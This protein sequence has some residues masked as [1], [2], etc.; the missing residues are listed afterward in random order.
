MAQSY[1]TVL[2]QGSF[3][4][5]TKCKDKAESQVFHVPL[6]MPTG[7]SH[8]EFNIQANNH[9]RYSYKYQQDTGAVVIHAEVKSH[10]ECAFVL[11]FQNEPRS[12][13][14]LT[15]KVIGQANFCRPPE[16]LTDPNPTVGQYRMSVLNE[17]S[18]VKCQLKLAE[19]LAKQQHQKFLNFVLDRS[20]EHLKYAEDVALFES[21]K[22]LKDTNEAI[23]FQAEIS[24]SLEVAK[25]LTKRLDVVR[26][27]VE[28]L[29][30]IPLENGG[31]SF[32]YEE[33]IR[34]Y[35]AAWRKYRT[36]NEWCRRSSRFCA[37]EGPKLK[38]LISPFGFF[39]SYKEEFDRANFRISSYLAEIANIESAIKNEVTVLLALEMDATMSERF[40]SQRS[41]R[42]NSV[43][44]ILDKL[45]LKTQ[46]T[47][48]ELQNNSNTFLQSLMDTVNVIN[49][50]SCA[51]YPDHEGCGSS[52]KKMPPNFDGGSAAIFP[53]IDGI[54]TLPDSPRSPFPVNPGMGKNWSAAE[55]SDKVCL[56]L[57]FFAGPNTPQTPKPKSE[58]IPFAQING[59]DVRFYL[60]SSTLIYSGNELI[61][62]K[63][64]GCFSR[65]LLRTNVNVVGLRFVYGDGSFMDGETR[66]SLFVNSG[67]GLQ[68]YICSYESKSTHNT[69]GC[70]GKMSLSLS[71]IDPSS[72]ARLSQLQQE[73]RKLKLDYK[74]R[75]DEVNRIQ[76]Y[77]N[78]IQG[79]LD[80]EAIDTDRLKNISDELDQAAATIETLKRDF[81]RIRRSTL[82]EQFYA[83]ENLKN[84][85][86]KNREE[87]ELI[88]RRLAESQRID[89]S[90]LGKINESRQQFLKGVSGDVD[91]RG[92]L[93]QFQERLLK[94]LEASF[95]QGNF[96]SWRELVADW[97]SYKQILLYDL[98]EHRKGEDSIAHVNQVIQNI[99]QYISAKV[100][101]YGFRRDL[102]LPADIKASIGKRT[103]QDPFARAV[104]DRLN[105]INKGYVEPSGEVAIR[106]FIHAMLRSID[107]FFW[108]EESKFKAL[109]KRES[110]ERGFIDYLD[111]VARVGVG[112]T[113]VIGDFVDFCEL[114][115]GRDLCTLNGSTLTLQERAL[116]GLGLFIG[117]GVLYREI[118]AGKTIKDADKIE[119]RMSAYHESVEKLKTR[120]SNRLSE[121]K[122]REATR[123]IITETFE[124]GKNLSIEEVA[125]RG[126]KL[127][128]QR[129]DYLSEIEVLDGKALNEAL[130]QSFEPAWK[131]NGLI[132]KGKTTK[133]IT[134]YRLYTP[135]LKVDSKK[136]IAEALQGK[137]YLDPTIVKGKT[138]EEVQKV[139]AIPNRHT[140]YMKL[141]I[142]VGHEIVYGEASPNKFSDQVVA[143]QFFIQGLDKLGDDYMTTIKR[144]MLDGVIK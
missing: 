27:G 87:A 57:E 44:E 131:A 41:E 91:A 118:R 12:W 90:F 138:V 58:G 70:S 71:Q 86:I 76:A 81:E 32:A 29:F 55:L 101:E 97:K 5:E 43:G 62:S 63:S 132:V 115:T 36:K 77:L 85:E 89:L 26:S 137:W 93:N 38:D 125:A 50:L 19:S 68:K 53:S 16:P 111:G 121:S 1:Q 3:N 98:K 21:Q 122:R 105:Q 112:F 28:E 52:S 106:N 79:F 15:Y 88:E 135:S 140:M 116:S 46:E 102:N 144:F 99:D 54:P 78:Q 31:A 120:L 130:G 143:Y 40:D 110:I 66:T 18:Y 48:S 69:M 10:K 13:L 35:E 24:K 142:P 119:E 83:N 124:E 74:S 30:H 4:I 39:L 7:F 136:E 108:M 17:Q 47:K 8:V 59:V 25:D 23:R 33:F 80:F 107:E 64:I 128:D 34:D 114:V 100:D 113:P 126:K 141:D 127:F 82:E 75:I 14:R 51:R 109:K 6:E 2:H 61:S 73:L 84:G 129:F 103:Q 45:K 20:S 92:P 123:K 139:L 72:H 94:D 65:S 9:G 56:V 133:P 60:D 95:R 42:I 96:A 49:K 22:I 104:Q 67:D 37:E 134:V 117:S 11:G